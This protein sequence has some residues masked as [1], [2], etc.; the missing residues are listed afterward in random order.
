MGK[1]L[2]AAEVA[3]YREDGYLCPIR[4]LTAEDAARYRARLEAAEAAAGGSLPGPYK[5]KPHLVY[6]FA[7]ELVREP[8]ILDAIEAVIG[9]DILCWESVFFTKEPHT[10][11]FISWHQDITYWGLEAEG[12]VVTAWVALSPSMP[13]SAS[14]PD[15]PQV[16]H[17]ARTWF[18]AVAQREQWR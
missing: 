14:A 6:T 15:W 1:L 10:R 8:R 5:H 17:T 11:D 7:Q 2:S 16:M 12:D 3:R 13:L 18:Q 9:P 4:A